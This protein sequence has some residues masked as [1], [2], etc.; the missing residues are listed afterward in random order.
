MGRHSEIA[1]DYPPGTFTLGCYCTHDSDIFDT[2]CDQC[3][4][5]TG[6]EPYSESELLGDFEGKSLA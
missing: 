6:V 3:R 1:S 2:D 5:E 4:A